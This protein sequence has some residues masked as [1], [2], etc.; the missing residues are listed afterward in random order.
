MD[1]FFVYTRGEYFYNKV[2][3]NDPLLQKGFV[4]KEYGNEN[5]L[6]YNST[7]PAFLY[8]LNDA[9]SYE[10]YH[11]FNMLFA[12]P[13]FIVLYEILLYCFKRDRIALLG[14]VFLFFIPRFLG[15]IPANPKDIPFATLYLFA[16][17]FIY[18]HRKL[19]GNIRILLIGGAIGLATSLRLIGLSLIFVYL[20]YSLYQQG[21]ALLKK[22]GKKLLEFLSEILLVGILSFAILMASIPYIGAD[23][24]NHMIELLQINT[25]YPWH[26]TILF[27]GTY[28][29]ESSIPILYLLVWILISTPIF[30]LILSFMSFIPKKEQKH[31]SLHILMLIS[32]GLQFFMYFSLKPIIYNGVRHYAFLLPQFVILAVIGFQSIQQKYPR[33]YPVVIAT[34]SLNL[35]LI[36][37]F[38]FKSYPYLYPFFNYAV[39]IIPGLEEQFDFDYWAASDKE[40]L[41]WLKKETS[42]DMNAPKIYMCSKSMS[43][44]YY[45][46]KAIDTNHDISAADYIVCYD[47][48]KLEKISDQIDGEVIYTVERM[49]RV[50]N[51][52]YKPYN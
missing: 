14:P 31:R 8:A 32:I 29:N 33:I 30:I 24:I 2:V 12:S 44:P 6:Y 42:E 7:Y 5:L 16:L 47:E 3:G 21:F 4:F 40:A 1:E 10:N 39:K 46:P 25:I 45:F 49:G 38:Y 34:V 11:L 18:I 17:F 48:K 37:T 41:I 19:P 28:F 43:L 52:I 50:Y 26:G 36:F 13:A 15:H 51:T 9:Q 23:P 22:S 27:F 20:L 35:I